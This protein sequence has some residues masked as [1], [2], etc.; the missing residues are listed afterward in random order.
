[1]NSS[2]TVLR[3]A[4]SGLLSIGTSTNI[5]TGLFAVGTSTNILTVLNNGNVG[6]GTTTP[7]TALQVVGT[8]GIGIASS[9]EGKLALYNSSTSASVTLQASTAS[10]VSF[11]LTLPSATGTAGQ[12][13]VTDGSGN[14]S[15]G[16]TGFTVVASTTTNLN[17]ATTLASDTTA[18]IT[19]SNVNAQVWITANV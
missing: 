14:L 12:A 8:V 11:T 3:V 16:S 10:T 6:I 18:G 19:P 4:S 17:L 15:W 1:E 5:A 2:T 9:S 7:S 13:L